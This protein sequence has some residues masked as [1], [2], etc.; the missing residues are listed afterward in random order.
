MISVIVPA[1]NR[2]ESLKAC[3]ASIEQQYYEGLELIIVDDCS[4]DG[5]AAYLT[6]TY[7]TNE[8]V[9]IHINA[10]NHG[11]NYA[12]NRGVELASKPFILF[13]D[14]DDVMSPG[15][16]AAVK[17]CIASHPS[18]QHFLFM[19]SDRVE[20]LSAVTKN[21][22]VFYKDWIAG[23]VTG[24]FTHV[25]SAA[26]MKRF[27]FFEQ[28]RM[29]EHLNW[30]RVKKETS[31]QLMVPLVVADRERNRADCLTNAMKLRD[32]SVI[33]AKFDSEKMFYSMYHED[34][35]QHNPSSFKGQ[36]LQAVALGKACSKG[37][38]SRSLVRYAK[39]ARVRLLSGIILKLPSSFIKYGIIQ[40]SAYK[41][42][43]AQLTAH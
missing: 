17:A 13:I 5:T 33:K 31:P 21:T 14:S 1:Y 27:P 38:E 35:S 16:L 10:R 28:F 25:I 2:L 39:D 4:T 20:E 30:L 34:L 22:K 18:V 43:R 26:V 9:K 12:R 11:V 3:I 41:A 40:Y 24:D 8:F 6:E 32:L 36:L 37:E 19:V 15:S 29:Y 23:G 7:S 42:R